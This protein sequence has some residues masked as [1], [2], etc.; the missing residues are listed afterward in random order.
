MLFENVGS[1]F[2]PNKVT[3]AP[4]AAL[5]GEKDAIVGGAVVVTSILE[6]TV[7]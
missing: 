6:T 5:N 1:K 2:V 4:G 3:E 7:C